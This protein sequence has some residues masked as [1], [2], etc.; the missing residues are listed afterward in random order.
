MSG[1]QPTGE[2]TA[3]AVFPMTGPGT[4]VLAVH[5]H[6]D[7]ETWATGAA[8]STLS[9]LGCTVHL[10]VA[11]GGEASEP[12]QTDVAARTR[13]AARL[14]GASAALGVHQWDW[15]DEGRWIDTAGHPQPHSLTS[16]RG[17]DLSDVIVQH[18]ADI[19]PGIVLTVGADG[20]TGHPDH[21]LIHRAVRHATAR[22]SVPVT[23][24]GACLLRSDV[25][26]GHEL[27]RA[28]LGDT[29]I[30]SGRCTGSPAHPEVRTLTATAQAASARRTAV[31]CYSEGLG[32]MRLADL[33]LT[34]AGRGDSLL[35]RGVHDAIGWGTERYRAYSSACGETPE[36][37]SRTGRPA[38]RTP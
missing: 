5:A 13:R 6:P 15:L 30:G 26:R 31:D 35:L 38:G 27:L 1:R 22:L 9:A 18:L 11:S 8:L 20:L 19:K 24:L 29:A 33:L 17:E 28:E 36:G 34:Y 3:R 10:R 23:V 37:R 32:T 21:I 16:A 7:D 25:A 14:A 2:D 12:G 4:T